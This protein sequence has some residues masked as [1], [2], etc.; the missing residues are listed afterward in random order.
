MRLLV[1]LIF[2]FCSLPA[3]SQGNDT[4]F[5]IRGN[6]CNC[7][8]REEGEERKIFNK[9][10]QA[11]SFPGGAKD[12]KEFVKTNISSQFSGKKEEFTVGFVVNLQGN[13]S[14]IRMKTFISDIK[15]QEAKRLILLSGK[16]CPAMQHGRCVTAYHQPDF[17]F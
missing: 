4:T 7:I 9:A 2:I 16:W 10:Q 11:P 1:L 12:W 3:F 6:S 17:K 8:L 5:S 14:D 15:F 13:I